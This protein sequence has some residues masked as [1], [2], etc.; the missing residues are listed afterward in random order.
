MENVA[1][2]RDLKPLDLAFVLADRHR[3]E[4]CLRRMLVCAVAGVYDRS[5]A[6]LCELMR[7]AGRA[8]RTTMQSGAIASRLS[9]VSISVSPFVRLDVE[10]LM[11][12]A[13]ADSRFAASSN[14]VRVRVE[15][16]KN[17]LMISF[18]AK[19]RDLFDLARVDLAEILGRIKNADDLR[20]RSDRGCR[21]GLFF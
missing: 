18:A 20:R 16:S 15:F 10:T 19:R 14:D 21:E 4:Q 3:V 12:T 9:A 17:R 1:E 11:F 7:H 8:C 13:S 5:L 6:D 2:D